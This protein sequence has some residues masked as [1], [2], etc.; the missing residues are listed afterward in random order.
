MYAYM[1]LPNR[2]WDL[3]RHLDSVAAWNTTDLVAGHNLLTDEGLRWSN[4]YNFAFREP[5][6]DYHLVT[7]SQWAQEGS[8]NAYN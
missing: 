4:E 2:C 7:V 8:M 6:V 5:G 1:L 3:T